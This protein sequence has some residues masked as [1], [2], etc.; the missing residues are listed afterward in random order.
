MERT[1]EKCFWSVIST[2]CQASNG[3]KD[4][5]RSALEMASVPVPSSKFQES[6]VWRCWCIAPA[7]SRIRKLFQLFGISEVQLLTSPGLPSAPWQSWKQNQAAA[8]ERA[9][10]AREMSCSI[11]ARRASFSSGACK[12]GSSMQS[13]LFHLEQKMAKQTSD[14]SKWVHGLKLSEL[15]RMPARST[16]LE[17]SWSKCL[18]FF[19]NLRRDGL[20]N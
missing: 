12:N 18:P 16:L 13:N 8:M 3:W 6:N 7:G 9:E 19:H 15:A 2:S 11:S 1:H 10:M 5:P 14:R 20:E 4:E 17:A